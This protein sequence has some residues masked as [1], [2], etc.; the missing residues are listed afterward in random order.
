MNDVAPWKEKRRLLYKSEAET[1]PKYGKKPEERTYP[2]LM[3]F[4]IIN[5]DKPSG[6]TSHEVAS[7]VKRILKVKQAG[8]GGTL[9]A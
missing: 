2:K 3:Q 1:N 5:L 9:V 8:H 4:G 6:P 7:W